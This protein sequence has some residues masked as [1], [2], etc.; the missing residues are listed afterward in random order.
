MKNATKKKSAGAVLLL[1]LAFLV[2]LSGLVLAYFVRTTSDRQL[3]SNSTDNLVA[4]ILARSALD[5]VVGDFKQEII[6]GSS[7]SPPTR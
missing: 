6:N 1:V 5:V 2:L 4:D 3:A 7:G